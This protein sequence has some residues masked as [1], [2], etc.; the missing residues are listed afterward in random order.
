MKAAIAK[1]YCGCEKLLKETGTN[2]WS[3]N[4]LDGS[5]LKNCRVI[6]RRGRYRFEMLKS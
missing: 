2:E 3:V 1:F 4:N 5:A 6:R